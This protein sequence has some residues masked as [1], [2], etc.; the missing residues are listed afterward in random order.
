MFW[1][2]WSIRTSKWQ[3][4]LSLTSWTQITFQSCLPFWILFRARKAL[5]PVES[6]TELQTTRRCNR[7]LQ[8]YI[9]NTMFLEISSRS[10]GDGRSQVFDSNVQ[11]LVFRTEHPRRHAP[12]CNGKRVFQTQGT[13]HP[14]LGQFGR[15]LCSLRPQYLHKPNNSQP[16]LGTSNC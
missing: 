8:R 1:T 4:S 12:K 2:V 15:V 9:C 7:V 10:A 5:D 13:S 6:F 16:S 3:R 11:P 14:T